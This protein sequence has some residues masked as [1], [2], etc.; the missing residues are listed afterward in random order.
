MDI[1][2]ISYTPEMVDG[3]HQSVMFYKAILDQAKKEASSSKEAY[4][5]ADHV[6]QGML[7]SAQ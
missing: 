5:I 6:Y 3:L 7:K 2:K 4:E 1:E